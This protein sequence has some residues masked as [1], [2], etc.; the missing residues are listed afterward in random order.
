[1]SNPVSVAKQ[2][3]RFVRPSPGDSW[4]TIAARELAD[5]PAEEASSALQ[6]WNF[7]VFMR[8]TLQTE[9]GGNANP[10]LP[11]DIIFLEPPAA[12]S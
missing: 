9:P 4:E 3:R 12:A 11:S 2:A 10:I 5:L 6:S 1:M 7:H 8:V